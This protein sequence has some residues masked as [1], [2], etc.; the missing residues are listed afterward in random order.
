[1]TATTAELLARAKDW[2]DRGRL[3]NGDAPMVV[4]TV[5]AAGYP[6]ARWVLLKELDASGFVFF[7][8]AK[9]AKG[10]ELAASAKASLAFHWPATGQQL[11]VTGD[12]EPAGDAAADAYWRSRPRESQLASTASEQSAPLANKQALVDRVAALAKQYAGKDIPRPPHW[13]GYR[14][15][16]HAIEFWTNGE[17][18]LHERERFARGKGD[19]W[20][21]TLL[22]P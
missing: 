10:R 18:R 4:A 19:A 13:T 17:H 11:R 21:G 5:D 6:Q 14:V 2:I 12:V 7:T 9:S 8:N 1:M 16:P 20:T 22:N 15:I 3:A